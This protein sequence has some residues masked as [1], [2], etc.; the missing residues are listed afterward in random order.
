[1]KNILFT[2]MVILL[3]FGV[4]NAQKKSNVKTIGIK[5]ESEIVKEKAEKWFKEI[6]VEKFFKDPYSYRLMGLKVIPVSMKEYLNKEL[7]IV[8]NDID[9]C[10]VGETDRNKESYDQC[11]IKHE[12]SKQ[13][14]KKEQELVDKGIETTYHTKRG[15]IFEHAAERYL[16]LA[17][18]I[19]LYLLAIEEKSKIEGQ[20]KNLTEESGNKLA[21]YDIRLDCYSKNS[22]G[23]EVLGRYSFPFSKEGPLGKNNGIDTVIQLNK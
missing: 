5:P 14:A 4:C 6:Y 3:S 23:N 8:Q 10:S 7:T 1:M 16:E 18:N 13:S 22:L 9:T 12:E 20:L 19:A 17:K 21:F 15:A 2:A 11:M